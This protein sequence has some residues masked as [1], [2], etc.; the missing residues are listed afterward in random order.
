MTDEGRTMRVEDHSL[1]PAVQESP[2]PTTRALLEQAP[3]YLM[4][5]IGAYVGYRDVQRAGASGDLVRRPARQGGLSMFQHR[6]AQGRPRGRRLAQ[7][8]KLQTDP[9]IHRDYRALVAPA[10]SPP[11]AYGPSAPSCARRPRPWPRISRAKASASSSRPSPPGSRS[12]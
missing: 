11:A 12:A 2:S 7:D 4:P 3:V 9:P 1:D 5:E 6:E 8:T 10:P